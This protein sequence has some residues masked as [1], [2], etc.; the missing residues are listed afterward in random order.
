MARCTGH[1][2]KAFTL[3]I[4][5][6]ELQ[7]DFEKYQAWVQNPE[8]ETKPRWRD[9]G[10]IADMAIYL[11]M[12]WHDSKTG[13]YVPDSELNRKRFGHEPIRVYTCRHL[14]SNG[15]CGIYE[16]RPSMC[17]D[18]PYGHPCKFENCTAAN[19]GCA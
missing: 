1:C 9:I 12:G 19:G 11:G 15:D 14:Q 5:A 17:R 13:E 18:Y 3:P 4:S 7:S 10:I 16:N 8:G 2:C 6:E